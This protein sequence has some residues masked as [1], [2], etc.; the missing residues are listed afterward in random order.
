ME[1][2]S[3]IYIYKKLPK[4]NTEAAMTAL[5]HLIS[6]ILLSKAKISRYKYIKHAQLYNLWTEF[7]YITNRGKLQV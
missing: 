4:L 7:F 2:T 6:S 5:K 1:F 3:I